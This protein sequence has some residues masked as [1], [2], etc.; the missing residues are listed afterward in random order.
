MV[1]RADIKK[2]IIEGSE[3]SIKE[4]KKNC[5]NTFNCGLN[6]TV[7]M[8]VYKDDNITH[9]YNDFKEVMTFLAPKDVFENSAYYSLIRKCISKMFK[10]KYSTNINQEALSDSDFLNTEAP[11]YLSSVTT[12]DSFFKQLWDC[13]KQCKFP[14]DIIAIAWVTVLNT[15][16]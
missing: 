8:S 10:E 14:Y 7:I 4:A 9:L 16:P 11:K 3:N 1:T 13:L 6:K 12:A 15:S 2:L 5:D